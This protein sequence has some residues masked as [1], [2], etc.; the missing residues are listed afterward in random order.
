MDFSFKTE[1]YVKCVVSFSD[2]MI[3]S[4]VPYT[5]IQKAKLLVARTGYVE[6]VREIFMWIKIKA[7]FEKKGGQAP[8]PLLVQ[9]SIFKGFII[10]L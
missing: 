10:Y 1:V 2:A 5:Q 7:C 3:C 6:L 9:G 4:I 8:F